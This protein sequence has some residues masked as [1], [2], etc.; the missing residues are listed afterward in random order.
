MGI[1]A[2]QLGLDQTPRDVA[3]VLRG[4]VETFQN[5]AAEI[6]EILMPVAS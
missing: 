1:H 4:N 5:A 2:A 6:K 3:C